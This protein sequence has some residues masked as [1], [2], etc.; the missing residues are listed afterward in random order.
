MRAANLLSNLPSNPEVQ[1][2]G[3]NKPPYQEAKFVR[4]TVQKPWNLIRFSNVNAN[5]GSGFNRVAGL[6]PRQHTMGQTLQIHMEPDKPSFLQGPRDFRE[7]PYWPASDAVRRK[8]ED[9]KTWQTEGKHARKGDLR[10]QRALQGAFYKE[11][12]KEPYAL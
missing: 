4:A 10:K 9:K 2:G 8:K 11:P 5:E 3:F 12:Y 6:Q 1:A 7:D